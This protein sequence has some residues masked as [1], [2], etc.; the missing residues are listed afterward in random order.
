MVCT[1]PEQMQGS[2]HG[3][4]QNNIQISNWSKDGKPA[5]KRREDT[6]AQTCTEFSSVR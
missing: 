3:W 2:S 4:L 6:H 1:S 5:T